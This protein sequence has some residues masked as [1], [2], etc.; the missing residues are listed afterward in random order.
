[1]QSQGSWHCCCAT[2][3]RSVVFP[4]PTSFPDFF[5]W[6]IIYFNDVLRLESHLKAYSQLMM[7]VYSLFDVEEEL[8]QQQELD[9]E[10][11]SSR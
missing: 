10:K 9:E 8:R 7:I 1:M 6:C 5:S 11:S 3:E 4:P 2:S